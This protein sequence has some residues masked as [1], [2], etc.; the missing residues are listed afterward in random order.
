MNQQIIKLATTKPIE[1]VDITL[2]VKEFLE[3]EKIRT[4]LLHLA[5]RHTTMALAVNEKCEKLQEDMVEF[6]KKVVPSEG[7]Y[8]HNEV[9][10]DGRPNAHSH[11]LSLFLPS[12]LCL[13]ITEGDLDLGE[14]QSLFAVE[15]DGPRKVREVVLTFINYDR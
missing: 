15:L 11:L 9:A 14:W 2:K 12:Q 4:G 5:S 3:K 1:I 6:L 7:K 8:H 10:V 13:L